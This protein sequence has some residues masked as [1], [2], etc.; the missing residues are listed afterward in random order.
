MLLHD[1]GVLELCTDLPQV[2]AEML[3][4]GVAFDDLIVPVDGSWE[5]VLVW[6]F[7]DSLDNFIIGD[8]GDDVVLASK[9][10]TSP[11]VLTVLWLP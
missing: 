8:R 10:L 11:L 5:I 9:L 3:M 6:R 7:D 2:V 4:L 1:D